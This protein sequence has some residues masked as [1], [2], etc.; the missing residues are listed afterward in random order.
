VQTTKTSVPGAIN[1]L[2]LAKRT[3]ARI[4]NTCDPRMHPNDSRVVS[5]F[6]VEALKGEPI[7]LYGDSTPPPCSRSKEFFSC[8]G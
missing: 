4:F 6:I 3:K 5:N 8:V 2:G 1:M 7:K